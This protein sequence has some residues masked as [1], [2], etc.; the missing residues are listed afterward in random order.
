LGLSATVEIKKGPW[1]LGDKERA[2]SIEIRDAAIEARLRKQLQATGSGSVEEVLN[3]LLDTQEE[4]D[5]WV[6]ENR[7]MIRAKIRRG[8]E[9]LGRGEGIPEE[10]LRAHLTELKAKPE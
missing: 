3:R 2:M 5:R 9:Q 8:I 7:E 6:L 10:R 1:D 4:Q